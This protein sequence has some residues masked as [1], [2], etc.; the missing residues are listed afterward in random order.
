MYTH[1]YLCTSLPPV[2]IVNAIKYSYPTPCAISR[3]YI[4]I[5]TCNILQSIYSSWIVYN[6]T[7]MCRIVIIYVYMAVARRFKVMHSCTREYS[8]PVDGEI[9]IITCYE[10]IVI[11][12]ND[13]IFFSVRRLMYWDFNTYHVSTRSFFTH[14]HTHTHVLLLYIISCRKT[15]VL[16]VFMCI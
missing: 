12:N 15:N 13:D 4:F 16:S 10:I 6:I 14:T 1:I 8:S 11:Y 3:S 2:F 7:W 5:Y 9:I